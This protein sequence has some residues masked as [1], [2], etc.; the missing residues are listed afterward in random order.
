MKHAICC[1][2]LCCDIATMTDGFPKENH[3]QFTSALHTGAGGP[4]ANAACLL[5]KW[6]V[7]TTLLSQIGNDP[8]SDIVI[9]DLT[10]FGVQTDYLQ[11]Y[12][13]PVNCAMIISNGQN[14]TR[15]V[16]SH[17]S[18]KHH[19]LKEMPIPQRADGVLVDGHQFE[20]SQRL[21]MHAAT[22]SVLDAG[23]FRRETQTLMHGVTD[24]I[25]S[26][27]FFIAMMDA[28]HSQEALEMMYPPML[29]VTDGENP[30]KEITRDATREHPVFQVTAVDTLAAGDCFHG[31]YL[32]GRLHGCNTAECILLAAGAA[33]LSVTSRGGC[34][35]F[36]TLKE[37]S[38]LIKKQD[39]PTAEN[40]IRRLSSLL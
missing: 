21:L 29:I 37:T 9:A 24:P 31:A 5:A 11:P 38:E 18:A 19:P 28:C 6:G 4:A 36:P 14:G 39:S 2:Y 40:L 25:A 20:W 33:A 22:P 13:G 27:P 8:L 1:G 7:H 34:H 32:F 30:V 3:K 15:T 35:S 10:R 26:T 12:D 16:L 17:N 23:S